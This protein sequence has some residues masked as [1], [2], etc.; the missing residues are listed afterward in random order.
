[1]AKSANGQDTR[2]TTAIA[3]RTR[4]VPTRRAMMTIVIRMHHPH[5]ARPPPSIKT[6][7]IPTRTRIKRKRQSRNGKSHTRIY[8]SD[9]SLPLKLFP[10]PRLHQR[11][12]QLV[13]MIR[14]KNASWTGS[15]KCLPN[16][17][18]GV[19]PPRTPCCACVDLDVCDCVDL[20]LNDF[21]I[22]RYPQP[23]IHL[24]K[25]EHGRGS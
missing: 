16:S 22:I 3:T 1:M 9:P 24:G 13:S 20:V 4:V 19:P 15:S 7:Q 12:L 21:T 25:L 23:C 14:P 2:N 17:L 18:G 11:T 8:P 5:P 6:I 10:L